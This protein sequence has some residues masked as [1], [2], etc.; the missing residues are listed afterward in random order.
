MMKEL[1]GAMMGMEGRY[2][3]FTASSQD[4]ISVTPNNRKTEDN[5]FDYKS[6]L[7]SSFATQEFDPNWRNIIQN[8][9]PLFT[10]FVFVNEFI[11]IRMA[12]FEYGLEWYKLSD[13][14]LNKICRT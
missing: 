4:C 12:K 5:F 6:N 13:L 9:L 7:I 14:V 1:L 2:I 8:M 11:E 3:K 10:D